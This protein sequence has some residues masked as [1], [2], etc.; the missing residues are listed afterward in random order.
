LPPRAPAENAAP[1]CEQ[2]CY[3]YVVIVLNEPLY[4]LKD[5]FQELSSN[6]A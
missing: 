5:L 6:L 1:W 2:W 4:G 3:I